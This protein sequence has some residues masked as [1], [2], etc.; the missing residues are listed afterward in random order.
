[1][2]KSQRVGLFWILLAMQTRVIVGEITTASE[3]VL[4]IFTLIL[5]AYGGVELIWGEKDETL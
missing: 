1:M 5:F 4:S 3:I 2:T